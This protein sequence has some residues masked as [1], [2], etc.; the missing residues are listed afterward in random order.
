MCCGGQLLRYIVVPQ[1]KASAAFHWVFMVLLKFFE[2]KTSN[3][4][5]S[6]GLGARAPCGCGATVG[7][8]GGRGLQIA[9]QLCVNTCSVS[10]A[11]FWIEPN[12]RTRLG[13]QPFARSVRK[14]LWIFTVSWSYI[15]CT[16]RLGTHSCFPGQTQTRR[17]ICSC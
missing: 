2:P 11:W 10:F 15:S 6:I 9:E 13:L 7:W 17:T 16:K 3:W 5:S 14:E 8:A 12:A 1:R 4:T